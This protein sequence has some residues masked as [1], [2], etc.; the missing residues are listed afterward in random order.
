[1]I[2]VFQVVCGTS[3]AATYLYNLTPLKS[4]NF[5]S[6][7]SKLG[8]KIDGKIKAIRRFGCRAFA[9][10]PQAEGKF[11]KQALKT[12]LLGFTKPGYIL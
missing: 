6:P 8:I 12:F 4:N 9:K 5:E 3:E 11:S 1:M 10:I 2:Q 7:L